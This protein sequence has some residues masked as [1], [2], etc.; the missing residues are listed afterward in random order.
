MRI[1]SIHPK[2]LDTKGLIALWRETL[3]ARKV[4]N[5]KTKGYTNHPQLE[6]FKHTN[7]P[8]KYIDKYLEFVF[9]E[10]NKRGYHFDE[11]K[12]I[13]RD[14]HLTLTV[15]KE[16]MQYELKHLLV[17]LNFREPKLYKQVSLVKQPAPHPLFK[18]IDGQIENWEVVK[19]I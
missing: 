19:S 15:N 12:F 8:L 9:D 2:Y 3:L 10:A 14:E 11:T 13:P 16:Q 4:L 7:N 6:R 18:V 1:W 5:G 17:K